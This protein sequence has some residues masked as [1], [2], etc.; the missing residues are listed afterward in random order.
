[1]LNI[2]EKDL[3]ALCLA[4]PEGEP[5]FKCRKGGYLRHGNFMTRVFSPALVK[6]NIR[7]ITFHELRDTATSQAI[8]SGADVLAVSRIA[9]H[10]NPSITLKVF[11]HVLKDSIGSIQRALDESYADM[12]YGNPSATQHLSSAS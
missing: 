4:T 3:E 8:A 12:N 1:M 2:L 10:A 5:M 6:A 11:G 7:H 9:G